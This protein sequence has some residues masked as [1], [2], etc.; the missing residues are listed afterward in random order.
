[1][2]HMMQNMHMNAST[3]QQNQNGA[4]G[5]GAGGT[6]WLRVPVPKGM[7]PGQKIKVRNERGGEVVVS[8]PP[9]NE[10]RSDSGNGSSY[11]H[12]QDNSGGGGAG[13]NAHNAPAPAAAAG[14]GGEIM[15]IPVP[16]GMTPGQQLKVGGYDVVVVIPPRTCWSSA[17]QVGSNSFF[18]VQF[19]PN[20][21]SVLGVENDGVANEAP[22]P[23][24]VTWTAFYPQATSRYDEP[25]TRMV[26]VPHVPRGMGSSGGIP[27]NGRHKSLLIGIN[28]TGTRSAL[29]GCINDANNMSNL[30]RQNGFP[31]DGSHMLILSDE[32]SRGSEY[33]PTS[34]NIMKA[35]K[36]L[37]NDVRRGDILFF[38]FSGH[39]SQMPDKTGQEVDGYNETIVPLDYERAGQISDDVLWGTLV[40]ALP[41]GARLTALMD[42]C[43]SGT[44]L[45]LPFEYNVDRRQWTDDINPA[46][47]AGDVVLF[48][49]CEDSQTSADVQSGGDPG[50][51][52]TRAFTEAY[53][54]N[55]SSTYHEFLTVVKRQ[56]KRK[57][58]SQRPQL[59]ASQKFDPHSRVFSLGH[60]MSAIEP[61]HNPQV[62]RDKKRHFKPG[63]TG[64]GG[65]GGSF[66]NPMLNA[67]AMGIGALLFADAFF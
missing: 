64:N 43:H 25:P 62:G 10:W 13:S 48:S 34:S 38:H 20:G 15:R 37:M 9:R 30:L 47:S 54:T 16:N 29:K 14:G 36:W 35:F 59:T 22:P 45:D 60:A 66:G 24:H 1:M 55:P 50:G 23:F 3:P 21:A 67:A 7:H 2:N 46:H 44:G 26:N 58:F 5:A 11:F 63:R 32:R 52:M 40:R 57:R 53:R 8:I 56:L 6:G 65:G 31:R 18:R 17:D 28:Y 41:D 51:A 49:G 4:G 27:P 39:G 42:M 19:G 61:N 12:I 33:Q